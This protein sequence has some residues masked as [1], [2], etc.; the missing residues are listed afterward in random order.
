MKRNLIFIAA[1][2]L[3]GLASCGEKPTTDANE[4]NLFGNVHRLTEY[5]YNAV[6]NFGE[7]AQGNAFR[8]EGE[9]DRDIIFTKA[10]CFDTVHLMTSAGEDVGSITYAY[11]KEGQKVCEKN[12][13]AEGNPI[14]KSVFFYKKNQLDRIEKYT[15]D[16][17]ISGRVKYEYDD[18]NSLKYT[19]YY[20]FKGE[21][22]Q[23]I[24]QS[25]SKRGLPSVTKVYGR[26]GDLANWRE[27]KYNA[28]GL[29]EK[30]TVK[31][32]D[33]TVAMVVT[34]LYDDKGNAISQT[35]VD[36]AGEAFIPH[37]WK[38]T[39]DDH[40][41]WVSCTEFEGT[42]PLYITNRTFEYFK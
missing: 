4:M 7:V 33:G 11:N 8:E 3:I 19:R 14:D 38:Y 27:E 42:K 12:H 21:L 18:Q 1:S 25:L 41:N 24:E 17:N 34:F 2:L 39:Y 32:P 30:L 5:K 36:G 37:T 10:G 31:E 26:E 28:E 9:W 29:L 6:E 15:V 35:A 23:T 13:D 22:L 16:E 20:N 40:D